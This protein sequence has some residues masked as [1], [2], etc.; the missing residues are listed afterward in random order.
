[1][2]V[3]N[4]LHFYFVKHIDS[5]KKMNFFEYQGVYYMRM[6]VSEPFLPGREPEQEILLLG[7]Q[8]QMLSC[9]TY[10]SWQ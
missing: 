1:M 6:K 7:L 10:Y 5:G 8:R 2:Q 3:A 4:E 9:K